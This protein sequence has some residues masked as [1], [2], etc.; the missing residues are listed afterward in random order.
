MNDNDKIALNQENLAYIGALDDFYDLYCSISD[1]YDNEVKQYTDENGRSPAPWTIDDRMRTRVR[2]L[3]RPILEQYSYLFVDP[4]RLVRANAFGFQQFRM[5]YHDARASTPGTFK[6]NTFRRF[7]IELYWSIVYA[8]FRREK[9]LNPNCTINIVSINVN[10]HIKSEIQKRMHR[11]QEENINSPITEAPLYV[12]ER[13]SSTSCYRYNHPV[14]PDVFIGNKV[15]DG[16]KNALPVH[17]C[18]VCN[19]YF[20]GNITLRLYEKKFGKALLQRIPAECDRTAFSKFRLE[21]KLHQLGYDVVDGHLSDAERQ[22]LLEVLIKS[23]KISYLEVCSTIEQNISLFERS[24][25][26]Q[27]AILK[28][29]KDLKFIGDSIFQK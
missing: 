2:K 5:Y 11:I 26:H 19:K 29:K 10:G 13:L 1:S 18:N 24:P 27:L 4:P 14:E 17:R 25:R 20:I 15:S 28:W 3:C 21:S 6:K 7:L 23:G 9:E 22:Q 16:E 12:F 8:L